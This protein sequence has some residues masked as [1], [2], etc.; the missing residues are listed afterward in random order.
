MNKLSFENLLKKIKEIKFD[1]FD[2]VVAI[3]KGG[4]MP[5]SM[6]RNILD[7]DMEILWINFRDFHHNIIHKKPKL[8]KKFKK[9]SFHFDTF[10]L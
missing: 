5:A 7:I 9:I 10:F 1:E 3:G 4:I 8:I 2:L 6:I